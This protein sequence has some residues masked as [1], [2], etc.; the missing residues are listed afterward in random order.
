MKLNDLND[1]N[2]MKLN[3]LNDF[4]TMKLND[5][6]DLNTM[7]LN[8]LNDLN[9]MKLNDLI[10]NIV[11]RSTGTENGEWNTNEKQSEHVTTKTYRSLSRVQR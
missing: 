9:T 8:D 2:T 4:N 10:N 7:K 6:N 1:L 11:L 5:L 3:D